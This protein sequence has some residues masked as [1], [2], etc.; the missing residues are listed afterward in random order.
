[1]RRQGIGLTNPNPPGDLLGLVVERSRE[2][3]P[4]IE[5]FLASVPC[6][7]PLYYVTRPRARRVKEAR[8]GFVDA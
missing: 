7:T 8:V 4:S 6:R 3:P 2:S 1:M 5:T